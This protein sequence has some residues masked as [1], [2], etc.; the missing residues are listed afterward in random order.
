MLLRQKLSL[1]I[2]ISTALAAAVVYMLSVTFIQNIFTSLLNEQKQVIIDSVTKDIAIFDQALE[3]VETKWDKELSI[4]LPQAASEFLQGVNENPSVNRH[5]LLINLRD[6]YHFSD[7]HIVNENLVVTASTDPQEVNLDLSKFSQEYTDYL[8]SLLNSAQFSAKRISLSD[9]T[10]RLKKY[11]YFSPR[12]SNIM[13]NA[14]IDVKSRLNADNDDSL[15]NYVFGEYVT[16]LE[17][18]YEVVDNID[19]WLISASNQ[20]S[21]F[22]VGHRADSSMAK[23]LYKSDLSYTQE[24]NTYYSKV[25]FNAYDELGFK[26]FLQVT[27]NSDFEQSLSQNLQ[28]I[29]AGICS[30]FCILMLLILHVGIRSVFLNRLGQLIERINSKKIGDGNLIKI[31]GNDELTFVSEAIDRNLK[32][33]ENELEIN[34]NLQRISTIDGL[35]NLANRR[36]MDEQLDIMWRQAQRTN[37]YFSVMMIDVDFF[38]EFNDHYGHIAGD[39]CLVSIAASLLNC[40]NRPSDFVARYGGEEFFCILPDTDAEGAKTLATTICQQVEALHI[41]HALSTRSDYVTVSVGCLTIHGSQRSSIEQIVSTVDN[42]LY[43]AKRGGR[44]QVV[45]Q[46]SMY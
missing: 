35:T 25:N 20:W 27:F 6:K 2:V 11:A 21:F 36:S 4:S 9:V 17:Q 29:I 13:L 16:Q 43:D 1:Y 19:L 15:I 32:R 3:S 23:Y 42:L 33:I 41:N 22:K 7:L 28:L 34:K 26:A 18:K 37:S 38:K 39:E 44:N 12:S 24:K 14:D 46:S 40:L 8:N 10:G 5:D 45:V 30:F 31:N